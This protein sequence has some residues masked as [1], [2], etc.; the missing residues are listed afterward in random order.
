[1]TPVRARARLAGFDCCGRH[2]TCRCVIT[3][4]PQVRGR[5]QQMRGAVVAKP[6]HA[7][8]LAAEEPAHL[9]ARVAMIDTQRLAGSLAD[10]TGA[11]LPLPHGV[12]IGQRDA[13]DLV[14]TLP[15]LPFAAARALPFAKMRI[16]LQPEPPALAQ[17]LLVRLAVAA[18]GGAHLLPVFGVLRKS[19]LVPR[20][21]R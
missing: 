16:V 19:F 9:A 12:I 18:P 20:A 7:V 3:R 4:R 13:V 14:V 1:M 11:I 8:A 17:L 2:G 6:E 10:G 21:V 15:A 5:R